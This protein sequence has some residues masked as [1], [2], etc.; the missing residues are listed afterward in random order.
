MMQTMFCSLFLCQTD[1]WFSSQTTPQHLERRGEI[2]KLPHYQ[3]RGN[4]KELEKMADAAQYGGGGGCPHFS[5]FLKGS[6]KV[7]FLLH[8]PCGVPKLHGLAEL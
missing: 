7:K 5:S 2:S 1:F 4:H 8:L 3:H 6:G